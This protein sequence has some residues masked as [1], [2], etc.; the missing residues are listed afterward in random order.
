MHLAFPHGDRRR[1]TVHPNIEYRSDIGGC[2]R[3]GRHAKRPRGVMTNIEQSLALK[4]TD[5]PLRT[6]D[7]KG[8]GR[9][10]GEYDLTAIRQADIA[11]LGHR[12][13]MVG[14]QSHEH[15]GGHESE[16][17]T[18]RRESQRA[19]RQEPT[20]NASRV[21]APDRRD[22][23]GSRRVKTAWNRRHDG[24]RHIHVFPRPDMRRVTRQPF[25]EPTFQ[26]L[27][28][29]IFSKKKIPACRSLRRRLPFSH[30]EQSLPERTTTA[31]LISHPKQESKS[32]LLQ[33][34]RGERCFSVGFQTT[35]DVIV[36][37]C[38]HGRRSPCLP[39]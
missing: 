15:I 9:T 21:P 5:P 12:R 14:T 34:M 19:T 39:R 37:P 38:G 29:R 11:R 7:R 24:G 18:R 25:G 3:T 32:R 30:D 8:Y 33:Q 6:V 1:V 28:I 27:V 16:R 4:Q 2:D 10:R 22:G 20:G 17:S 26:I 31:I 13:I 35:R 23:G 36:L